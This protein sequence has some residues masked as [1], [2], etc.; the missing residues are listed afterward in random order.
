MA[1]VFPFLKRLAVA[2][3]ALTVSFTR[4]RRNL[5]EAVSPEFI[6]L[7][8]RS[9]R[10]RTLYSL[11]ED[12]DAS[13]S[14][15]PSDSLSPQFTLTNEISP[16]NSLRKI[17]SDGSTQ[18]L[19]QYHQWKPEFR[20][21]LKLA[22]ECPTD[23][24]DRPLTVSFSSDLFPQPVEYSLPTRSGASSMQSID[25]LQLP[26]FALSERIHSLAIH[27]HQPGVYAV[28]YCDVDVDPS[29]ALRPAR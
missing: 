8:R 2:R 10:L 11:P 25:L 28:R 17:K 6:E 22:I 26:S 4:P 27:L 16:D 24:G 3:F 7:L 29:I 23:G 21:Q 14:H 13:E 19:L 18:I 1:V 5:R 15:E 12:L 20:H 9:P